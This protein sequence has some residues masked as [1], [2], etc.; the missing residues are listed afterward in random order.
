[1]Q[2]SLKIKFF[3]R[4]PLNWKVLVTKNAAG[5][6]LAFNGRTKLISWTH[7]QKPDLFKNFFQYGFL[8]KLPLACPVSP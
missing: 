7:L 2:K 5:P 4:N 8:N 3:L 6:A 1:M